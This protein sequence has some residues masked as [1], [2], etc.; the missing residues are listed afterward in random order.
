[1]YL[2]ES[3]D[4]AASLFQRR[5]LGNG[6]QSI[7]VEAITLD[8]FFESEVWSPV[9][10]IKMDIEGAEKAALEGMSQLAAKNPSLKLI[11]EFSPRVQADAGVRPE[12]LFNT[13]TRLGFQ[14]FWVI[15]KGLRPLNMAKDIPRLIQMAGDGCVNLFCER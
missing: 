15:Q 6:Q 9:H 13:L 4:G 2:T 10:V 14:R 5:G 12:E 3:G 1:L 11:M 8:E 7:A